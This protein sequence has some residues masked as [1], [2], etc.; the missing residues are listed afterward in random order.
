MIRSSIARLWKSR[1]YRVVFAAIAVAVLAF[2]T[3]F[4]VELGALRLDEHGTSPAPTRSRMKKPNPTS[5]VKSAE[6]EHGSAPFHAD[7]SGR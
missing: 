7:T 5:K 4:F 6:E 1:V 2:L 3:V